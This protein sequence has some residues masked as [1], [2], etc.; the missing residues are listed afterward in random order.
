MPGRV[1]PLPACYFSTMLTRSQVA[2][3]LGKSLAT[4]RRL[5]GAQLHPHVDVNGVHRFEAREVEL[6]ARRLHS[7]RARGNEV[8]TAVE[9]D[10]AWHYLPIS[11]DKAAEERDE[12][13]V[14]STN[15]C[16]FHLEEIARLKE[17]VRVLEQALAQQK[18]NDEAEAT[19][20]R[21]ARNLLLRE[22]LDLRAFAS[23]RH[24]R[25]IGPELLDAM[26]DFLK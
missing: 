3:R 1:P 12:G 11:L 2:R 4:V 19:D 9:R 6:L 25:Q 24:I 13:R 17:Q 10:Q 15:R 16:G 18:A 8:S 26:I 14:A 5:E 22:L 20:D 23:S 21:R 7:P